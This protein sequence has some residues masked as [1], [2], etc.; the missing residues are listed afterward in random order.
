MQSLLHASL[1]SELWRLHAEEWFDEFEL[2]EI[3]PLLILF[4][5]VSDIMHIFTT[6]ISDPSHPLS[7]FWHNFLLMFRNFFP[8][9]AFCLLC[10]SVDMIKCPG[11]SSFS[12]IS[13]QSIYMSLQIC[14][15]IPMSRLFF[16]DL[17]LVAWPCR[18]CF[19]SNVC[20]T[21]TCIDR[22]WT[23]CQYHSQLLNIFAFCQPQGQIGSI[24]SQVS[25]NVLS[26]SLLNLFY[27]L[28]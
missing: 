20:F 19:S 1:D 24:V 26:L 27:L 17:S 14:Q 16:S 15:N 3:L 23:L 2:I 13:F 5:S 28:C 7:C 9:I 4:V 11:T 8:P 12:S 6:S 21:Y 22:P 18:P 10:K 25:S